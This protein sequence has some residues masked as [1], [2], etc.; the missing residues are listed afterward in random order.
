[1]ENSFK[2]INLDFNYGAIKE[3]KFMDQNMALID[4]VSKGNM[5][6]ASILLDKTNNN[7]NI[8]NVVVGMLNTNCYIVENSDECLIID[9]G[10]EFLK[11]KEAIDKKVVGVL[12]TH[13]HF[14]HIGSLNECLDYYNT[15][16]YSFNNLKE[17]LNVIGSFE[18]DVI[19]NPG[20]TMDSMS[21]IF[22]NNMFSGDFI[23]KGTIGRWDIG[24]NLEMMRDSIRRI[25]D[26]KINYVIYPGHGDSTMLYDEREMLKSYI[27]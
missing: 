18:F 11:I 10:D 4:F 23:F 1:M 24:G 26:S 7:I 6:E 3:N 22:N 15:G 27:M 16:V 20:H 8:K 5:E 13:R 2:D 17:G 19:F 25:L 21:F 9:P 14:D 12:L